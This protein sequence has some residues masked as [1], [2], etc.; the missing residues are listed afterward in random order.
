MKKNTIEAQCNIKKE[1]RE[2]K[3]N[4][5]IAHILHWIVKFEMILVQY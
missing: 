5:K 2:K 4:E 3:T 1:K